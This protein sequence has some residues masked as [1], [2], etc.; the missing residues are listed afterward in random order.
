MSFL[1]QKS[2]EPQRGCLSGVRRN[3]RTI[4]KWT[5]GFC[6]FAAIS[7]PLTY[8]LRLGWLTAVLEWI[9]SLHYWGNAIFVLLFCVVSLPYAIGGYGILVLSCGFLYGLLVG[10]LTVSISSLIGASFGYWICRMF[11]QKC[12]GENF[13][14]KYPALRVVL[15]ALEKDGFKIMALCRL[16]P[17][18][19]GI[20][21]CIFA[22]AKINFFKYAAAEFFCYIPT[23]LALCYVGTTANKLSEI[24][25][26]GRQLT[27]PEIGI[28]VTEIIICVIFVVIAAFLGRKA[29][30]RIKKEGELQLRHD[31]AFSDMEN[32]T[33]MVGLDEGQHDVGTRVA[34]YRIN[35]DQFT[36]KPDNME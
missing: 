25:S 23:Q 20:Q 35:P 12:L 8:S 2:N 28:L 34:H 22:L 18:P 3:K 1:S 9:Q 13:G 29:H 7:I 30:Q 6:I 16:A 10:L 5:V 15:A 24:V 31:P 33:E 26:G 21:N 14:K 4:L 36:R 11:G 19:Y 32:S 17:I 27:P